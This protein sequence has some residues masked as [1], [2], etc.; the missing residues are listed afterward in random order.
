MTRLSSRLLTLLLIG[1]TIAPLSAQR[2]PGMQQQR[3]LGYL[4]GY[5]R[6]DFHFGVATD[7]Q[8]LLYLMKNRKERA[9]HSKMLKIYPELI[10]ESA[11]GKRSS[12]RLKEEAG[13][14]TKVKPG[15]DH[16]EVSFT[17]HTTGDAKVQITIKY[18]DDKVILD[19]K[20]LEPGEYK[21][22]KLYFG[23]KIL[24]PAF[25]HSATY[26]NDKKK[27]EGKMKRDKLRIV[28]ADNGKAEKLKIYEEYDF[29]SA[30]LGKGVV[31]EIESDQDAQEGRKIIFTT[32]DGKS[33]FKIEN[34]TR[35][36]N[37]EPW[38]G[39]YVKWH[40]PFEEVKGKEIKPLVIEVK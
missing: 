36:R 23:F 15:L 29:S 18:D 31:T 22:E 33:K 11:D 38:R 1:L 25:Y 32:V 28:R 20:V 7:G 37:A 19:G 27:A 14:S 6:R 16:E 8:C 24:M 39:F 17:A 5:E 10:V 2:M 3:W 35:G 13:F 21:D 26:G 34:K 12:K 4:S 30:E 9:S 40:R